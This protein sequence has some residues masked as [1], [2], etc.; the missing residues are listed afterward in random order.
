MD[1]IVWIRDGGSWRVLSC[2]DTRED[3]VGIVR[4]LREDGER[5]RYARRGDET[6]ASLRANVMQR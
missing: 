3:A 6:D 4:R 2:H 5:V 1:H